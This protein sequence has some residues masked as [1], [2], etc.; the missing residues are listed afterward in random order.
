MNLYN[1]LL[2]ALA[3][4]IIAA[5]RAGDIERAKLLLHNKIAE[6]NSPALALD[7]V[8]TVQRELTK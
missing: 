5:Y 6:H 7:L 8:K 2:V 1:N 3:Q 4:P